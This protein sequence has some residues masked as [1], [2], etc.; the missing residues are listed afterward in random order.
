[1]TSLAVPI[2]AGV[3]AGDLLFMVGAWNATSA[4]T[5]FTTP[6]GW[7][8]LSSTTDSGASNICSAGTF[9]RLADGTEA[10]TTATLTH[11]A[12][13]RAAACS[14]AFSD[15]NALLDAIAANPGGT[16][17][18]TAMS[19]AAVSPSFL[20]DGHVV[21]IGAKQSSASSTKMTW[22]A[23]G[24]YAVAVSDCGT[25]SA[26]VNGAAMIA[27]LA[28]TSGAAVSAQAFTASQT[29][30]YVG[31]SALAESAQATRGRVYTNG[32]WRRR[33]GAGA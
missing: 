5:T 22:T 6:S 8:V 2:G 31:Y 14:A 12:S 11:S 25:S 1:V 7:N 17:A 23:P 13:A 33:V 27:Y 3:V 28:L 15:V 19:S 32:G 21:L 29:G 16:T 18:G 20:N 4:G 30:F 10:S 24:S 9:W 26:G